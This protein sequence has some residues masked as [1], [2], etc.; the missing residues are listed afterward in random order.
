MELIKKIKQAEKQAQEIIEQ[1][2]AGVA[3]QIEKKRTQRLEALAQAEQDRKKAV[4]VAVSQAH[5]QGLTEAELLKKQGE[6]TCQQLHD[7][8]DS[9][10]AGATAKVI[11]Y[12]KG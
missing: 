2:K 7:K 4:G 10:M 6:K 3:S 1:A 9:K 5:E 12:L 11:D 8:A